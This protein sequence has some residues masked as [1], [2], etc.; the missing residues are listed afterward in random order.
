[1]DIMQTAILLLGSNLGDRAENLNSA[2]LK[3]GNRTGK[4]LRTSSVYE[5]E[6]WGMQSDFQFYNQCISLS[7]S[8]DPFALMDH[9]HAIELEMGRKDGRGD[10][11]DRIID[12]DILFYDVLEINEKELTIPHPK[13][14]ERR[15][16]LVPLLEIY[17]D[18]LFPSTREEL[19]DILDACEDHLSVRKI[20]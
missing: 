19:K 15:F 17:P 12:I 2:I 3:L 4:V 11:K 16:A 7:T 13:I 18:I 5:S 20:H 14:R 9:I 6:P 10:F 1:M 8:L